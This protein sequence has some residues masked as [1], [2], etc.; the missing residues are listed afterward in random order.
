MTATTVPAAFDEAPPEAV[1]L[2]AGDE[3]ITYH[4]FD[5][6]T[7][8]IACGLLARGVRRGDRVGLYGLNQPEWLAVYVAAA[9]IGAIV[10][11]LNVRYR[12][13]EFD[14]MLNQSGAKM[15]VGPGRLAGF[16]YVALFDGMRER[17]PGVRDY[18]YTDDA[19][20]A[21]LAAT[22]VDGHALAAAR[23]AVRP[24]DPVIILYTSGTTGLP[25]GAV[26]TQA[27]ILASARAQA[28]H[29]GLLP[30][31][32]VLGHLPLNHV[33]GITCSVMAAVVS[34][35]AVALVPAFS[36]SATL[37]VAERRRAT[38]FG[39]VPT[40]FVLML[41][42]PSF[43]GRD[44]SSVR[45]CVAGGSNVDPSLHAAIVGSFPGAR[46]FTL[47]GLSET[48][49]A[50][51]MSAPDDDAATVART[52]GVALAGCDHRVAGPDGA[53]LPAGEAGEL[54]VRGDCVARGYWELPEE[55][56]ATFLPG[57]WLATGDIV[58][59]EP[60]GHLVLL[61]RLKEMYISGGFNVYPVEIENLLAT[62]PGVA[63][64]AGIGVPDPVLGEVGRFYVVP[65]PDAPAPTAAEL[66]AFCR[67]HLADYKVPKQF[68]ITADLPLTPVGKV[69]KAELRSR[70]LAE[71]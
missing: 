32:T 12:E 17:L 13:R 69:R 22:P 68:A 52:L 30:S 16:D 44:L 20:Y 3:V 5:K 67:A 47:Y 40:M 64:A 23:A 41:G 21:A 54:Q 56:A 36:P 42:D 9:K 43:P 48:S 31:D 15:L 2:Y 24:D 58:A 37:E 55:S 34:G 8:H 11:T 53:E 39:G 18:V 4:R 50:C 65:K 59:A 63:L 38:V 70:Y 49:G 6:L 7:G 61:G 26:I 71:R 27:S 57:G 46:V 62:H 33:G 1:F 28:A 19:G 35:A 29:T 10:V 51:V 25:K 60:D 14:Y 66:E 45:M